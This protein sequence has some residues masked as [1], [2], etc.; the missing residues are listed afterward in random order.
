MKK[1]LPRWSKEE[2]KI[3]S[4]N[5]SI[6]EIQKQLPNRSIA[7][8]WSKRSAIGANSHGSKRAKKAWETRRANLNV[9]KESQIANDVVSKNKNLKFIING[10]NLE[11]TS[12]AKNVYIGTS[13]I[14]IDF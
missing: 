11:L 4:Q 1:V 10:V 12:T 5:I 3:V 8:I 14:K 7:A 13:M 9:Q 2:L 6:E